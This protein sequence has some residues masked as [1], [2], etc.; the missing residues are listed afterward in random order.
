MGLPVSFARQTVS[1]LRPTLTTDHGNEVKTYPTEGPSVGGL[2]I[3]PVG[4]RE[5]NLSNRTATVTQYAVIAPP[6]ADILDDDHILYRGRTYQIL[7]EVQYQPS[8]SGALDQQTFVMEKYS[9]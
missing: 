7:G 2:I 5:D 3:E 8:P 1:V 9:G 4:S 6:T